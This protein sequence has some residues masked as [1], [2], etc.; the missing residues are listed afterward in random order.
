MNWLKCWKKPVF[1]LP[2]C[3]RMS[4]NTL[5]CDTLALA[6]LKCPAFGARAPRRLKAPY[7]ICTHREQ[8]SKTRNRPKS[9]QHEL[10][11]LSPFLATTHRTL[12][13][14]WLLK[15]QSTQGS[16]ALCSFV[17]YHI[18]LHFT[19]PSVQTPPPPKLLQ[20]PE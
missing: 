1:A 10:G 7:A 3:Q 8:K 2:G 4:V 17:N 5:L 15:P 19:D 11:T 18:R 6:D 13:Q 14:C 20:P 12:D 9:V 16:S